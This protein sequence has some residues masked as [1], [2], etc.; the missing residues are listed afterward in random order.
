MRSRT[1]SMRVRRLSMRL[2]AARA[3]LRRSSRRRLSSG[4]RSLT[5]P[6][7]RRI[8]HARIVAEPDFVAGFT[9]SN[10]WTASRADS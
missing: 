2:P 1:A 4:C 7:M 3:S 6:I 9:A 8:A 5:S 10:E